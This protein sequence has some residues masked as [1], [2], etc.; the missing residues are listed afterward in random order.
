MKQIWTYTDNRMSQ[1]LQI[2]TRFVLFGL[3][4]MLANNLLLIARIYSVRKLR[5][6]LQI[7]IW[8]IIYL[9]CGERCEFINDH[10]S[11]THNLSS[12]GIKAWKKFRP[13]GDSNPWPVWYRC[14]TELSSHLGPGHFVNLLL[15]P[16]RR[17]RMEIN[18]WKINKSVFLFKSIQAHESGKN[19]YLPCKGC[20]HIIASI[21]GITKKRSALRNAAILKHSATAND[22]IYL[23]SLS[24]NGRSNHT[25]ISSRKDRWTCEV[26]NSITIVWKLQTFTLMEISSFVSD[27]VNNIMA[28]NDSY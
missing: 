28:W 3:L 15:I 26:I 18:I 17:W 20:F 14:S 7:N 6:F 11:Y 27:H 16:V 22:E 24:T 10:R 8:K 23:A 19:R 1:D 12:C 21:F 13:K 25:R 9:N 5:V 2:C 4:A